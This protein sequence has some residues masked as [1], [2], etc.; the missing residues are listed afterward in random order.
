MA[1][2]ATGPGGSPSSVVYNP[3]TKIIQGNQPFSESYVL[4]ITSPGHLSANTAVTVTLDLSV[5]SKPSA[6]ITDVQ[7]LSFVS[8]SA[9]SLTF[10][11]PSEPKTVTVTVSVPLGD[12]AGDYAYKILPSGWP[13][14]P[15]G[16]SDA[17]ATINATA[18]PPDTVDNSPPAVVLLSP[19]NGTVYTYRPA[20]GGPV[21][22]PVSFSATVGANGMPIDSMLATV[23]GATVNLSTTG[24]TTLAASSTGSVDLTQPG[25]YVVDVAATNRNGTSHA[26]ADITVVVEAPPP[27]ITVA[28]PTANA[29]F[30]YT[31]G[32]GGVSVPVSFSATSIYGDITALSATLNGN[33]VTLATSGVGGALTATGSASLALA[34]PGTYT[35]VFNASNAYGA[36][37]PV[38][39][40]FTVTGIAPL[41]TVAIQS[42]ANGAVFTRTEGDPATE[43]N[44]TFTAGTTYQT[45]S[46]VIATLDGVPISA[47]VT[48]LNTISVSG[49]GSL[50]FTAGG[51]HTLTVVVSNGA[52][53]ASASTSF[54][55]QQTPGQTCK[56]VTW[57]PPISLNKTIQGGSEMPIKFTLTCRGRFVRDTSVVIAIYEIFANGSESTPTLYPY[58]GGSPNPPDYAITGRQYHLNFDT[59]K[60]KHH[61]R[62][63]VYSTAT[64]SPVFLDSKDLFTKGKSSG[65]SGHGGCGDDDDDDDDDRHRGW[66]R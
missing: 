18:S 34:T 47:S 20:T 2:A 63:E 15:A 3:E 59:A 49:S 50:S 1:L 46:S 11:N 48:G 14:N 26:T 66:G 42:P 7:A 4:T 21:N 51:N 37:T 43:V 8:L 38:T 16:L 60:G 33:P 10:N 23:G 27:T 44:Y 58:G 22:V 9:T 57:L 54:T 61:Y 32:S 17:G 40:P 56:D 64:G 39:I 35:L 31:L 45:I 62:I 41:P 53:T 65:G 25:L 30:S 55:V 5:L 19:A 12:Y 52:A 6:A 36:A 24:L 28:S 29:N 13:A